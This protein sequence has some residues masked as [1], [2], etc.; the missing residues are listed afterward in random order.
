MITFHRG[1]HLVSRG[2]LRGTTGPSAMHV[3]RYSVSLSV[4]MLSG[5]FHRRYTVRRN[6]RLCPKPALFDASVILLVARGAGGLSAT[7]EP[8]ACY[9]RHTFWLASTA[10]RDGWSCFRRAH[11]PAH[12]R[13]RLGSGQCR[14]SLLA[15]LLAFICPGPRHGGVCALVHQGRR[16]AENVSRSAY[17]PR[18]CAFPPRDRVSVARPPRKW[19]TLSNRGRRSGRPWSR[20]YTRFCRLECSPR[21]VHDEGAP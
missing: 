13:Y 15:A 9:R 16:S 19:W 1:N 2:V 5:F 20:L 18:L 7:L 21:P 4:V 12:E 10:A 3:F 17:R 8:R 11:M 6:P 14:G